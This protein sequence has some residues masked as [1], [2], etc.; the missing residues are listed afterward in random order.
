VKL[1]DAVLPPDHNI[2]T[3]SDTHEEYIGCADDKLDEFITT[4]HDD[5]IGYSMFGGDAFETQYVSHKY[6]DPVTIKKDV[7][8]G[9]PTIAAAQIE[10]SAERHRPIKDK[11]LAWL[12]GNHELRVIGIV[13]LGLNLMKEIGRPEIY[14]GYSCKLAI[15]DDKGRT[16]YKIYSNHGKNIAESRAGTERQRE[17]N[18]AASLQR[19]LAPIYG[20][21]IV[22]V[23]GHTHRLIVVKPLRRL[24]LVDDGRKIKQ[25]YITTKPSDDY[26]D[27]ENRYYIN[28]GSFFRSQML[29]ID[30]Y[31][32]RNMYPPTEM[33][34]AKIIVRDY[35]VVDV[36]KVTV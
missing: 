27:P 30:T 1:L 17:A 9:N 23:M 4:V 14:A 16:R 8:S 32:E 21:C 36:E 34:Y 26:I 33:G 28:S 10:R 20:D 11:L 24:Y 22:M 25:K 18:R 7:S 12:I 31:A 29:D 6:Y 3:F 13:N 35:Q 15:K 5:P 2:Y 19:A